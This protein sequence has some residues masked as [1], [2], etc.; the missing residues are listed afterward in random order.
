M[1][2]DTLYDIMNRKLFFAIASVMTGAGC[3]AAA[4]ATDAFIKINDV[5]KRHPRVLSVTYPGDSDWAAVY[6]SLYCHGAVVENP[7]AAFRVY[8]N[9]TQ[10]VD[11]YLKKA[12]RLETESVGF[13]PSKEQTAEGW[14]RDVLEIKKSIGCGSFAAWNGTDFVRVDSVE[15]RTQTV[16]NDSTVQ[17]IDKGWMLN[18]H[19]INMVQTYSVRGDSLSLYVEIE[20]KGA[21][22]GDLFVTGATETSA[23]GYVIEVEADPKNVMERFDAHDSQLITLRPHHGKIRYKV[24][25][26]WL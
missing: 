25:P 3:F 4:P 13:Y 19:A 1:S 14:G 15:T 12:E 22:K 6:G 23:D 8:I 2:G 16:L 20:L 26:R 18:G 24:T 21:K 9:Q 17:V 5:K 7:W 11:L 10:S